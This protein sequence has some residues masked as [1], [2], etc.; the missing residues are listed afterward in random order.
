MSKG[1]LSVYSF[2]PLGAAFVWGMGFTAQIFA[3][4]SIQPF[5]YNALRF[6]LGGIALLPLVFLLDKNVKATFKSTV[7]YG[8][9]AG[10][11]LCM[12]ASFQ[13]IGLTLTQSAAKGG[14]FTA[15]YAV[16]V[17]FIEAIIFKK[18]LSKKIY[19]ASVL[20]FLGLFCI[21]I[22]SES[23]KSLLQ[24]TFGDLLLL[25]NALCYAFHIIF[26]DRVI[27]KVSPV[28]FAVVQFLTVSILSGVICLV[29]ETPN[30]EAIRNSYIP[31]IY[32]GLVSVGCEEA[33]DDKE[34]AGLI[35]E[36]PEAYR[37]REERLDTQQ[38]EEA[39]GSG[40]ASWTVFRHLLEVPRLASVYNFCTCCVIPYAAI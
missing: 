9:A 8:I 7:K 11:I 33:E 21:F 35:H 17:P 1:K 36:V 28:L 38:E 4:G 40:R 25:I 24:I 10:V 13:Q 12:G 5:F 37:Q 20:S 3:S 26:I 31:I 34:G 39:H 2:L 30:V 32:G 14:F 19:I 23:V 16:L 6:A 27:N 18:R 15:L 29:F 22:S